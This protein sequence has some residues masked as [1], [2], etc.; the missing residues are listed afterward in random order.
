[1]LAQRMMMGTAGREAPLGPFRFEVVTAGADT[2]QLPIYNG[3][4]Y[5]FHVDWGDSSSSDI[6]AFD[7]AAANHS[8]AGAGTYNVVITGTIIGWC[9]ANAGDKTLIHDISEWGVLDVGNA[10]SYFYG[11][12]NLSISAT[13]PLNCPNI[14]T[15]RYAFYGAYLSSVA[16]NLFDNCPLVTSFQ[17]CFGYNSLTTIPANLFDSCPLVTDAARIFAYCPITSIPAGL[18]D[19]FTIATDLHSCFQNCTSI[20]TDL[21]A[22]LILYNIE[23]DNCQYMFQNC[24][25]MTG[26]GTA[27]VDKAE[28]HGVTTHDNCFTGCT[29]LPDYNLIPA[30]WGG[31]GA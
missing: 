20:N 19:N 3:G 4:T 17:N 26:D 24:A 30:N 14:T 23:L 22:D 2:F 25:S 16:A 31:G 7:D 5:D 18:F 9:F 28:E 1:M 10:Q 15:F 11:C 12:S 13:D 27:F 6:T 21:P 8:Y 29:S